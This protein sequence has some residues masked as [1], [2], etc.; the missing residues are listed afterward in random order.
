MATTGTPWSVITI[1]DY[2]VMGIFRMD[3]EIERGS[4]KHSVEIRA[5]VYIIQRAVAA[6]GKLPC[7]MAVSCAVSTISM[8]LLVSYSTTQHSTF[9]SNPK[10]S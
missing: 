10:R 3:A 2:M 4:G 5:Q 8:H 1:A 9:C 6:V 7:W